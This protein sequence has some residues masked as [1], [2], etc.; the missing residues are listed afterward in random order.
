MALNNVLTC[1]YKYVN[2][3]LISGLWATL[4]TLGFLNGLKDV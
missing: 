4:M 2:A 3:K 1:F